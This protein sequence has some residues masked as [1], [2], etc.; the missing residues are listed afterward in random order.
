MTN[1]TSSTEELT[2]EID[3]LRKTKPHLENLL[4]AFGPLLLE[5][6]QWLSD[7]AEESANWQID[8]LRFAEGV[9]LNR[10]NRLFS[11][12]DP[13]GSAGWA[14]AK[15]ISL[16]F[17]LFNEDM[18]MLLAGFTEGRFTSPMHFYT[19]GEYVDG[20]LDQEAA[21]LAIS[22]DSLHLFLRVLNRFMLSKK[23]RDLQ[24]DLVSLS[25]TKG[26]CPICGGHP[27]L[28]I[29]EE[30]GQRQLQCADCSNTWPFSRLTCPYCHHEDPQ[31][32]SIFFVDGQQED[33]AFTCDKCRR[34]LLTAKR[35]VNIGRSAADL[36]AMSLIH[37]DYIL[38][39]K[40]YKPMADC[41]WNNFSLEKD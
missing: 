36:V 39:E 1:N 25:W 15:A 32:T 14:A 2:R 38:Q 34:Y 17:P 23:A 30:K 8:A 13:W 33:A 3:R 16:G 26:Y 29:L 19:G 22:P 40:G 31:N 20:Q 35:S 37:L 28:A 7:T 24:A 9:P 12:N 27:H 11:E 21:K 41:E 6:A 4:K 10:Q 5:K 18:A